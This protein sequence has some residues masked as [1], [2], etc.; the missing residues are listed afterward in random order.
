MALSWPGWVEV[1]TK[2]KKDMDNSGK[3]IGALLFGAAVGAAVG[4]LLAP[5]KGS[6]M[7][8]KFISGIK[9]IADDLA[10]KIAK[11]RDKVAEEM[12]KMQSEEQATE[13]RI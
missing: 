5:E 13:H 1:T 8:K 7:R 10:D 11:S 6:E 4:V 2:K 9:E 3:V 12:D